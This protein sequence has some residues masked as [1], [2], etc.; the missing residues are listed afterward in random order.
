MYLVTKSPLGTRVG[1]LVDFDPVTD[2]VI[3]EF[4]NTNHVLPVSSILRVRNDMTEIATS[5]GSQADAI[6]RIKQAL[7]DFRKSRTSAESSKAAPPLRNRYASTTDSPAPSPTPKAVTLAPS[8][9]APT[10]PP[11]L[12]AV[13]PLPPVLKPARKA[14]IDAATK[15]AASKEQRMVQRHYNAQLEIFYA[16]D[17]KITLKLPKGITENVLSDKALRIPFRR[18]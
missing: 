5:S 8:V 3:T 6:D 18:A 17:D 7:L 4:S 10:P 1:K 14:A 9:A 13:P 12:V 15:L 2:T 11:K 16:L